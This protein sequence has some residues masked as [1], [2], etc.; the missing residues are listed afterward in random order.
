VRRQLAVAARGIVLSCT[1]DA[2]SFYSCA[3]LFLYVPKATL[4]GLMEAAISRPMSEPDRA[5][6]IAGLIVGAQAMAFVEALR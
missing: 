5:R 1:R 2:N 6:A 3:P 4:D